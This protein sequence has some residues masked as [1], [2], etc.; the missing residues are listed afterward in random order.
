[1]GRHHCQKLLADGRGEITALMDA[2]P[3]TAS[4]LQR[5]LCP[6][7]RVVGGLDELTLLDD[8]DAAIICTPTAEH[9]RQ[10][11]VCRMALSTV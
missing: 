2:H 4:A 1:M 6:D 5:E 10:T 9:Y 11:V 8:I 7:A 3:A